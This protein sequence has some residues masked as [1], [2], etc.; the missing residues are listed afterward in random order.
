MVRTWH[1]F[2]WGLGSIP[3]RRTKIL[4]SMRYDKRKKILISSRNTLTDIPR[5]NIK[6]NTWAPQASLVAQKVKSPPAMQET[7]VQSLGWEDPL[8]EGMAVHSSVLA[9]RIPW[10]EEPGWLQYMGLQRVQ[11]D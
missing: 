8:E 2:F 6:P 11:Q 5:H 9:W 4:Q 3:G 1:F 7:H 10:T